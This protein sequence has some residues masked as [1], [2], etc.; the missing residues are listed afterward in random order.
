MTKGDSTAHALQWFGFR[1]ALKGAVIIGLLAGS[2]IALQAVGYYESY[3]DKAAQTA[4][5]TSLKSAPSLGILYGASEDLDHGV[6]GYV[7][8]RVVS[9]MSLIVAVWGLMS[10][11]KLLRGN[12]EDGRW[13]VIR[14][15]NTT[16]R[17]STFHVA[18]GFSYAFVLAFAISLAITLVIGNMP[19][20]QMPAGMAVL[21]NL[22]IF[23]PAMV[24]AS[25]G[26]FVS[27]LAI[28]RRRAL[29]YGLIPLLA[30]YLARG[31]GNTDP[32]REWLLN[33][34][35]FG[36]NQLIDPVIS[37]QPWWLLLFGILAVVFFVAGVL[38]SRRDLGSSII[39]ESSIVKS[40]YFLLGG[41][42]RF[43][44]R[45]NFWVFAGWAAATFAMTAII[46]N[47]ITI[48]AQATADSP[49]LSKSVSALAN[50]TDDIKIAFLGAGLVFVVMVLMIMATTIIASIRGDE[51]KQ[52]LD[53]ILVQPRHRTS[54]LITRLCIGGG[55]TL[56]ISVVSGL[57][58]LGVGSSQNL[59]LEFGKVMSLAVAMTG[60]VAFLL[61]LGTL[62]YGVLPRMAVIT[63]YILISWSFVIDLISSVVK[64]DDWVMRSSLFHYLSFNLAGWP[65]W[66][67]FAWLVGI[68]IGMAA[69]GVILF[70][71]RDIMTE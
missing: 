57:I 68:G 24:F 21:T 59:G 54:W 7:V 6:N 39:K 14:S 47:V 18:A 17:S 22:A 40:R 12:E 46:A 1:R 58:I 67:T 62:I 50:N 44:L 41:A 27:Q 19:T 29:L 9:F 45:Q 25:A 13:E 69:I 43:A 16:A 38:L 10:M 63:M 66:E 42:G 56:L 48:A 2:M 30:A 20:I 52:Y 60:T 11:T 70:T 64:L 8:Y 49:A 4:F 5:A 65:D 51:A 32:G 35:P 53:N 34:T 36:W 23:A 3:P 61:G 31:V 71:R 55:I 37:P 28:T 33:W 15:G 26:I